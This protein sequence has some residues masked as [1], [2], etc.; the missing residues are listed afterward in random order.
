MLVIRLADYT[1]RLGPSGI[2]LAN[3][4]KPT[5]LEITTYR[6]TYS[7]VLWLLELQIRRGRNVYTQV[8]VKV[9]L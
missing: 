5:C 9:T 8:K 7:T 3:S 2:F 1:D 4:T 6:I